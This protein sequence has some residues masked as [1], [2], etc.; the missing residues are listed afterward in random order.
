MVSHNPLRD[1]DFSG[2][3]FFQSVLV[4]QSVP[5]FQG[6]FLREPLL[7]KDFLSTSGLEKDSFSMECSTKQF[8]NETLSNILIRL[9]RST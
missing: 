4:L 8:D 2:I 1:F 7:N 9:I 6:V 3:S 5:F